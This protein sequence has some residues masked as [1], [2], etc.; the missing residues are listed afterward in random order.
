MLLTAQRVE[1]GAGDEGVNAFCNLH[2]SFIWSGA[3]PAGIPEANPGEPAHQRIE[4]QPGGNRVRSYL[5]VIAP[6]ETPTSE[7]LGAVQQFLVVVRDRPLP[8]TAT[9][10][11][12]T[13]RFGIDIGLEPVWTE[14]FRRLI[15]AAM[16]VRVPA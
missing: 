7:I 9:V 5:D 4:V 1:S 11:R 10:G 13:I 16:H 14:E 6:D 3:P 12:C 8:W 15:A 2:G